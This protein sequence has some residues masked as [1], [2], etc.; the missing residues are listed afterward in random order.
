MLSKCANPACSTPF[1]R[2]REG[3]LFVVETEYFAMADRR[4]TTSARKPKPARRAEHYWLCDECSSFITLTFDRERGMITVPLPG[5][6][7][8]KTVTLMSSQ[9]IP[10][11]T[12]GPGSQL[13]GSRG[14]G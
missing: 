13:L 4:E 3:K 14:E 11:R 7:G 6:V 8:K 9:G 2:L 10:P 1:R 12:E 5:G